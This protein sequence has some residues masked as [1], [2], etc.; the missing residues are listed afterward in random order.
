MPGWGARRVCT[1][2]H[3]GRAACASLNPRPE[4]VCAAW[5]EAEGSGLSLLPLLLCRDL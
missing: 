1:A 2:V 5:L 4:S 3:S